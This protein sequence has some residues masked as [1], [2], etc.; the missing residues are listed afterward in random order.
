[1]AASWSRH[2]GQDC[3]RVTGTAQDVL[4]RP[5]GAVAVAAAPAMAGRLVRDGDDVCFVPRFGFVDGTTYTV[6]AGGVVV[7]LVRPRLDVVA[8]TEVVA[9][10]PTA[11]V[12]P[13]NLLRC[14]VEFSAPMG[15]GDAAAHVWFVD[16]D[17][18][19]LAEALLPTEY[20]LWDAA[21]RRLTVL[22]D[23]PGSNVAW[24]VM[25]R[26]ATRCGAVS[27]FGSSSTPASVTRGA[28]RCVARRSGRTAWA[29][30]C[31][32]GSSRASGCWPCR[33]RT[34]T[35]RSRWTSVDRW[36]TVC[37]SGV[38]GSSGPT[39]AGSTG[40]CTRRTGRGRS[41]RH[42]RGSR[43]CTGWWSIPCWRTWRATPCAETSTGISPE[44]S[45][46][47][48]PRSWPSGCEP[49]RADEVGARFRTMDCIQCCT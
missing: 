19:P 21:H 18:E 9:I 36:T 20:E 31:A 14:Y 46:N 35:P 47:R 40:R 45:T 12:V 11:D 43:A 2:G 5:A 17:G 16:D 25:S 32:V 8:T 7:D 6:A 48:A 23:R 4:V 34:A 10:H 27:R 15:E 30:T 49:V 41:G 26:P 39:V 22:L 38:C 33:P 29:T 24:S 28:H 44:P 3:V 13:R 1:M 37:S 42:D